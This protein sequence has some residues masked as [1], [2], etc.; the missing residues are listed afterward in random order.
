MGHN[1][2]NINI[3]IKLSKVNIL[4]TLMCSNTETGCH[5]NTGTSFYHCIYQQ[6]RETYFVKLNKPDIISASSHVLITTE[7]VFP[8]GG[9][10]YCTNYF[11]VKPHIKSNFIRYINSCMMF[12]CYP[13]KIQYSLALSF[14]F[15]NKGFHSTYIINNSNSFFC[16]M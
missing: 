3:G 12:S 6:K 1:V 11:I 2:L 5:G 10:T 4:L 16:V 9:D 14:T 15:I 13:F 8:T 7:M